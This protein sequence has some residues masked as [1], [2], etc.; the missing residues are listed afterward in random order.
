MNRKT[1]QLQL[2]LNPK[3]KAATVPVV[4]ENPHPSKRPPAMQEDAAKQ[5]TPIEFA[6]FVM[7]RGLGQEIRSWRAA[8]PDKREV[9]LDLLRRTHKYWADRELAAFEDAAV[10]TPDAIEAAKEE[11]TV[12]AFGSRI[13]MKK[14]S[15]LVVGWLGLSPEERKSARDK[16]DQAHKEWVDDELKQPAKPSKKK[17]SKSTL[18]ET[19]E[20]SK[21]DRE[22]AVGK[23]R[24]T[25]GA[26]R[27]PGAASSRGKTSVK[28]T[29][30]STDK[31]GG[32]GFDR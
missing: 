22:R 6:A 9:T 7:Q 13:L 27:S 3:I 28:Q 15:K 29:D 30:A 1:A 21:P 26:N 10:R 4:P 5:L 24:R 23:F 11:L 25:Q 16:F 20:S 12:K 19:A 31:G 14:R 8:H 2:D 18:A 32:K 17:S